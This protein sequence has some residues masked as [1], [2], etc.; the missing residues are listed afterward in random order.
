MGCVTPCRF[1]WRP[2]GTGDRCRGVTVRTSGLSYRMAALPG[3]H[4]GS[5]LDMKRI[6]PAV[7]F[8]SLLLVPGCSSMSQLAALRLCSFTFSGVSDVR[9][10]GI[11]I[12][13]GANY[14]NLGVA[15]VARLTAAV[16]SK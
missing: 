13:P 9:L 15:D 11:S 1:S 4:R 3:T 2:S 8:A 12:G 7:L 16:L 6:A 14:S 5:R 10:A